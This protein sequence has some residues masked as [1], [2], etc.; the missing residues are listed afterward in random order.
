MEPDDSLPHSQI[1][2]TSFYPKPARSS[3]YPHI[4]LPE[5]PF[6]YYLPICAWVSPVVSFSL[7]GFPT[8]TLYTTLPSPIPDTC[9]AHFILLEFITRK[10]LGDQYKSLSSS[11]C[12]FLHFSVTSSLLEINILLNTL[13]SDTFL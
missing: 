11:L 13:F 2:V 10:I 8:K 6:Y 7:L 3:P 4:P 12:S 5:D 9:P 1:P